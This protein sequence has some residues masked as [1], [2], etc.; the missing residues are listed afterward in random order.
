MWKC[1]PTLLGIR[2]L[3]SV[4]HRLLRKQQ[5]LKHWGFSP[6]ERKHRK[7]EAEEENE[8]SVGALK[9]G[10]STRSSP[11]G[12]PLAAQPPAP[13]HPDDMS[14]S[15]HSPL[16]P[17]PG[18]PCSFPPAESP[19]WSPPLAICLASVISEE[20]IQKRTRL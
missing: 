16:G 12:L 9:R 7:E 13:A 17:E 10:K 2:T 15:A 11:P 14:T 19:S 6:T 5:Q 4:I 3:V 18:D 1:C 8:Q 20:D